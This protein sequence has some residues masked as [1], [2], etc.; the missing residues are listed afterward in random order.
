MMQYWRLQFNII[1]CIADDNLNQKS[2]NLTN[3]RLQISNKWYKNFRLMLTIVAAARTSCRNSE[4]L[5]YQKTRKKNTEW[6]VDFY[7][8]FW[9][10]VMLYTIYYILIHNLPPLRRSYSLLVRF[11][12]SYILDLIK[13]WFTTSHII[14]TFIHICYPLVDSRRNRP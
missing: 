10:R 12:Q 13:D 5:D 2:I 7:G 4:M 6:W 8:L 9:R 3:C 11:S 1:K 14:Y